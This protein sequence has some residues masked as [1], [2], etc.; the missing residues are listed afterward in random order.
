MQSSQIHIEDL[1]FCD[2][3]SSALEVVQGQGSLNNVYFGQLFKF[4]FAHDRIA[5]FSIGEFRAFAFAIGP[6]FVYNTYS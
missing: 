2:L 6:Y 4:S 5:S 1:T 3:E